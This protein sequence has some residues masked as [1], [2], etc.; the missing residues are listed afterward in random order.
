MVMMYSQP[1]KVL[2]VSILNWYGYKYGNFKSLCFTG[3]NKKYFSE[4]TLGWS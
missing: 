2:N 4:W 1:Y 3:K